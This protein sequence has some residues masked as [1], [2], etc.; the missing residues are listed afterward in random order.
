L[1]FALG[2]IPSAPSKPMKNDELSGEN[3]IAVY[4]DK[5]TTDVLPVVGYK[6]YSDSGLND[7]FKLIFDGMNQPE[8]TSYTMTRSNLS[9]VLTYR[10]YVTG[11]NFNGEGLKSEIAYIKA[12]TR[13]A[14][15]ERP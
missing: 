6:L 15:I 2:S 9:T 12:C 10:F 8:A 1:I 5:I 14:Y 7:D 4:W 13:P 3:S 11:I